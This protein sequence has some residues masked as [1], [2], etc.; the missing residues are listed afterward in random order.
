[1]DEIGLG[2]AGRPTV[3]QMMMRDVLIYV[4]LASPFVVLAAIL[5]LSA[6]QDAAP[7]E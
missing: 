1:M 7:E 6:M 4:F 3:A 2:G 5:A